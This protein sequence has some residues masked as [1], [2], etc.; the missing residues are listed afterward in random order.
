M[1]RPRATTPEIWCVEFKYSVWFKFAFSTTV[2]LNVY[3]S[4]I[5]IKTD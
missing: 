2:A 4:I 1:N 3:A 5:P